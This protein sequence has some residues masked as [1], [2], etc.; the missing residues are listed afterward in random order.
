M[1]QDSLRQG[2]RVLIGSHIVN[3]RTSPLPANHFELWIE[4]DEERTIPWLLAA[5]FSCYDSS[6]SQWGYSDPWYLARGGD[7]RE[8]TRQCV[9]QSFLQDATR[10]ASMRH[11]QKQLKT[12]CFDVISVNAWCDCYKLLAH[13]SS[14]E[15]SL[16]TLDSALTLLK[17][18]NHFSIKPSFSSRSDNARKRITNLIAPVALKE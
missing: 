4:T 2:A 11:H 14:L 12:Q 7:Q 1:A 16:C 3:S 17:R 10:E 13:F 18:I 8:L 9:R 6:D 5:V 15:C